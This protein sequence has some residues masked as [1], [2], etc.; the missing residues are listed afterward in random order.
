[1]KARNFRI[2]H[3]ADAG[4]VLDAVTP[5]RR[6]RP[7]LDARR[8][9][10]SKSGCRQKDRLRPF[11]VALGQEGIEP[12]DC[13]GPK[14]AAEGR[15]RACNMIGQ[16]PEGGADREQVTASAA[17]AHAQFGDRLTLAVPFHVH[18]RIEKPGLVLDDGL[19]VVQFLRRNGV[20]RPW[21]G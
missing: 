4:V 19:Q 5:R 14:A 10:C 8:A 3:D 17:S 16:H 2:L 12:G 1:M 20:Q 11:G 21:K 15:A 18:P 6:R 7:R 9:G 13:K